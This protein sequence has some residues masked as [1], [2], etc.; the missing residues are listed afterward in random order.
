MLSGGIHVKEHVSASEASKLNGSSLRDT[1]DFNW[2]RA[3]NLDPR[4]VIHSAK[5]IRR[6]KVNKEYNNLKS[7]KD[8]AARD[9][10][11][12]NLAFVG[13]I[14][15]YQTRNCLKMARIYARNMCSSS[16]Q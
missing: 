11:T 6:R 13:F 10:N 7:L 8:V 2:K 15:P 14:S 1:C 5:G 12:S 16:I 9:F 4:A 3:Y